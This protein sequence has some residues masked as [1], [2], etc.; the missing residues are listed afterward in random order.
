MCNGGPAPWATALLPPCDMPMH[1][2]KH[3]PISAVQIMR[4]QRSYALGYRQLSSVPLQEEGEEAGVPPGTGE[5]DGPVKARKGSW[6]E[7]AKGS[8]LGHLLPEPKSAFLRWV[9]SHT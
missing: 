4:N 6:A 8:R 2:H 9:V 1:T 5:E 3:V 7:S